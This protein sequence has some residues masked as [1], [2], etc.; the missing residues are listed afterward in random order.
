MFRF[1]KRIQKILE[2][3]KEE[4]ACMTHKKAEDFQRLEDYCNNTDVKEAFFAIIGML[5]DLVMPD[6]LIK[7]ISAIATI[8]NGAWGETLKN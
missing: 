5:T 7:D 1:Q 4:I 2:F 3:V 8:K 6:A